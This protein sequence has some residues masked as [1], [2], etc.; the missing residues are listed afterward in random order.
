VVQAHPEVSIGSYPALFNPAYKT[1]VTFDA[2][3]EAAALAAL[4]DLRQRVDASGIVAV[5]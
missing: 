3:T 4:E 1:R 2:R 5:E